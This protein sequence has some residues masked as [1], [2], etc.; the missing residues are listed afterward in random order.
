MR[1]EKWGWK[2][3]NWNRRRDGEETTKKGSMGV[4]RG[5]RPSVVMAGGVLFC[6]PARKIH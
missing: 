5:R 4:D 2:L 3:Y 1:R 6:D